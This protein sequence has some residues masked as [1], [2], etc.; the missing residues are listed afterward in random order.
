MGVVGFDLS[1]RRSAAVY[2]PPRWEPGTWGGVRWTT[3]GRDVAG[4]DPEKVADRL[5]EIVDEL[6]KFV[7]KNLG[8][9]PG[10]RIF[11]EDYAFSRV[12]SSV[13]G[14][15]ELHGA[16]KFAFAEIGLV[17]VPVGQMTARKLLLGK[18][19]PKDRAQ[20]VHNVIQRMKPPWGEG[21]DEGDAFTVA[22]AARSQLGMAA[23]S[24]AS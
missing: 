18:L 14:L 15:A 24:L 2:L 19:P 3:C 4:R 16:V 7:G 20:A 12:A 9:M 10:Q 11:V 17:V 23:V 13:T 6:S 1:L 21:S 8:A 22:N 5:V